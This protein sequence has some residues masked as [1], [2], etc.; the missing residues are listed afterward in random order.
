[1]RW[2]FPLDPKIKE[3]LETLLLPHK[4][5]GGTIR[6][7]TY[8]AFVAGLGLDEHLKKRDTWN[9]VPADASTA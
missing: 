4:V 9:T 8:R 2:S 5:S 1:M 6:I 3:S 7:R